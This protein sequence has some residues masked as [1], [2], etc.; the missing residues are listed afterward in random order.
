M[1]IAEL[2]GYE[3][4]LA[5]K[6]GADPD[7]AEI[8]RSASERKYLQP[9]EDVQDM[10]VLIARFILQESPVT[11]QVRPDA[12]PDERGLLQY[13]ARL[14][15]SRATTYSSKIVAGQMPRLTLVAPAVA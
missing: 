11:T 4:K 1:D 3:E 2:L 9:D 15:R 10:R 5:T 12:H 13:V 14:R 7:L 6:V 8:H